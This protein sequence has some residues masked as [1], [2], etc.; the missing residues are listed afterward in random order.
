MSTPGDL[1]NI[2]LGFQPDAPELQERR[3]YDKQAREF[4]DGLNKVGT[5]HFL[6]SADTPQ[7]VLNVL[8]PT[9]NSIAYAFA[10]RVRIHAAIEKNNTTSLEPRKPLWDKLVL[11]LESFDPVQMRYAGFEYRRLVEYVEQIARGS[12]SVRSPGS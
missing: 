1:L 10:L 4:V 8:D 9:V 6:K 7:D 2:L 5:S 3:E 12:G 11:F